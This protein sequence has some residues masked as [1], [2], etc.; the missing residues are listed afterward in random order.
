MATPYDPARRS[1]RPG[2][3]GP[4]AAHPLRLRRPARQLLLIA[5]GS[6]KINELMNINNVR[7]SGTIFPRPCQL[8]FDLESGVRVT[9]DVRYLCANF[10]LPR[11]L[12]SSYS[13]CTRQTDR[14]KHGLISP[15]I[16]VGG[17]TRQCASPLRTF[18][19]KI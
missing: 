13:R 10:G 11:P 6:M 5:V 14:Q 9:C 18:Q 12:F 4:A 15:P 8:T 2:C 16:R 17:I 19:S 3:C 7:E 1:L